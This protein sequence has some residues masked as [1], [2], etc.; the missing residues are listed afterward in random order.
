[1]SEDEKIIT[2]VEFPIDLDCETHAG[3]KILGYEMIKDD[4][5]AL[6]NY[7]INKILKRMI[8]HPEE[9]ERLVE[10]QQEK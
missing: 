6:V 7:A 3:L 10:N 2:M 4:D 8:K 9:L 1:M 5:Q